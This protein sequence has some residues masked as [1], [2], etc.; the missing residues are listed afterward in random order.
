MTHSIRPATPKDLQELT[1]LFDAYRVFYGQPSDPA[2]AREFL[3]TRMARGESHV[4]VAEG[5]GDGLAGFTQLYPLFS[6]VGMASMFLLNDLFVDENHRRKGV[7]RSL[8]DAAVDFACE[9]GA[10]KLLLE[11]GVNNTAARALYESAGWDMITETC[12]YEIEMERGTL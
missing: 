6:S 9:Q 4:L 10:A 11:T 7:A 12:F 3:E 2:G 1:R 8:L 5:E